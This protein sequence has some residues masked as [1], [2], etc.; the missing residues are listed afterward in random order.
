MAVVLE[1]VIGRRLAS[2]G[3]PNYVRAEPCARIDDALPTGAGVERDV[4]GA[5]DHVGDVAVS[6]QPKH[7]VDAVAG[8]VGEDF[9]ALGRIRSPAVARC[10]RA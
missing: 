2:T 5:C 10:S 6:N 4:P 9:V 8:D 1:T 3:S 7:I